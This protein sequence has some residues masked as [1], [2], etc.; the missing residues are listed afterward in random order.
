MRVGLYG[1][2]FDPIHIGHLLIADIARE[3]KCLD[4]VVFLP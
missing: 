1:G 3:Q 2:S 4:E